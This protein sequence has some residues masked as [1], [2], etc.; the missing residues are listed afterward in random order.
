VKTDSI[1]KASTPEDINKVDGV[2]SE[3]SA[4][5]SKKIEP[6]DASETPEAGAE[7][8]TPKTSETTTTQAETPAISENPEIKEPEASPVPGPPTKQATEVEKPSKA[9]KSVEPQGEVAQPTE[10]DNKSNG[11]ANSLENRGRPQ[12]DSLEP[13]STTVDASRVSPAP[14]KEEKRKKS[15]GRDTKE[16]VTKSSKKVERE[17]KD[18]DPKKE[19]RSK[20]EDHEK[21]EIKLTRSKS[22]P[23]K[24]GPRLT[25]KDTLETTSPEAP[26]ES[27]TL[28]KERIASSRNLTRTRSARKESEPKKTTENS[29]LKNSGASEGSTKSE[30]PQ[31]PSGE[32]ATKR[33]RQLQRRHTEQGH[34]P[35]TTSRVK[36]DAG[37]AEERKG[38]TISKAA[39][40]SSRT[41]NSESSTGGKYFKQS[42]KEAGSPKE[43]PSSSPKYA[44]PPPPCSLLSPFL[45]FPSSYLSSRF[46]FFLFDLV[47][48]PRP[49]VPPPLRLPCPSFSLYPDYLF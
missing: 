46:L 31:D 36:K 5:A 29:K 32:S 20:S 16:K 39:E 23:R 19:Q 48:F 26:R 43:K 49:L 25:D 30:T 15:T 10:R 27:L 8:P 21:K 34:R 47:P 4:K 22:K 33:S 3:T 1:E 41:K 14:P 28:R 37:T 7:T 38:L 18:K 24:N 35:N 11:E 9:P 42:N 12:K 2:T 13:P 17:D 45:L 40:G 44:Y 6:S